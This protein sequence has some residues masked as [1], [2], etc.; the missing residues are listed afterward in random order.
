[1][2]TSLG[3]A[4]FILSIASLA[5]LSPIFRGTL[6]HSVDSLDSIPDAFKS[7]YKQVDGKFV[8]DVEGAVASSRLAEFRDTNIALMN[9]LKEFETKFAGVDPE[10]H[11][12][13][14]SMESDLAAGKL[15]GTAAE[16]IL[17][18]RT[19][20]MKSEFDKQLETAKKE[21][22]TLR[23]ELAK[24]SIDQ[25]LVSEAVKQGLQPSATMDVIQRGRTTWKLEDGK[26]VAYGPDGKQRWNKAGE[27][28]SMADY[29]AE[30]IVEAPHLFKANAGAKTD[31]TKTDGKGNYTGENPFKTGN[32]TEQGKIFQQNRDLYYRLAAEAGVKPLIP[33]T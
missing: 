33:R 22:E 9:K 1:M 29:V 26:P 25:A 13:L 14:L 12:K 7:E 16:Q 18:E 32:L 5:L 10:K 3:M 19:K 27:A 20:A 28:F 2:Q 4:K 17:E 11:A 21:N 15:K 6:K 8:L 24:V 31:P 30:L 23:S